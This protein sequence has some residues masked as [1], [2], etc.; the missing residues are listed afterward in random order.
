MDHHR[1]PLA[2]QNQ[3][4]LLFIDGLRGIAA[5]LVVLYH[6]Y[7]HVRGSVESWIPSLISAVFSHGYLG[8]PIFFVLSGYVI[9]QNVG[10]RPVSFG[11]LGRFALRRSIRLDPPYWAAIIVSISLGFLAKAI[12]PDLEKTPPSIQ[13]LIAHVFYA[14]NLLGYG[15]IVEVFWTLCLEVQFYLFLVLLFMASQLLTRSE[16][17]CG[18]LQSK[19]FWFAWLLLVGA[20]ILDFVGLF[21]WPISGLFLP[22]WYAFAAGSVT[23]WALGGS[24][25]VRYWFLTL[26]TITIGLTANH[27]WPTIAATVVTAA[28]LLFAGKTDRM[29]TWLSGSILQFLGR[30][31]YSLYLFHAIV[32]WSAISLFKHVWPP[33]TNAFAAVAAFLFGISVSIVTAWIVHLTIERPSIRLSRRVPYTP[34]PGPAGTQREPR[35]ATIVHPTPPN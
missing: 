33:A 24:A 6:F 34:N 2:T 30:I 14:Q 21:P 19:P 31:S 22:Y 27:N 13:Q 25:P 8:V 10:L 35:D 20:S 15:D 1:S 16:N 17:I 23:C 5:M 26:G 3:S 18:V 7:G 29:S 9:T 12:F 28:A 11:F 32:G 4:R